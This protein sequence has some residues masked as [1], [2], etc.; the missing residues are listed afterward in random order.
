MNIGTNQK[1][2]KLGTD[3]EFQVHD[4]R[5]VKGFPQGQ[6]G[7]V[8]EHREQRVIQ[9]KH[10]GMP[11]PRDERYVVRTDDTGQWRVDLRAKLGPFETVYGLDMATYWDT[12]HAAAWALSERLREI[13]LNSTI[14]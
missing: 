4:F 2:T 9:C 11:I 3:L 5:G 12:N 1:T 7:L 14:G 8:F 6:K 13:E 10:S